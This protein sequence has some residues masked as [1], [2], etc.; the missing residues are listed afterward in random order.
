MFDPKGKFRP[1]WVG[2]YVIK[3][4]MTGGVVKLM[5][6]DGEELICPVNLDRLRKRY[7]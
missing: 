6:L 2:P 4:I 5:D 7:T 1:N 3:T